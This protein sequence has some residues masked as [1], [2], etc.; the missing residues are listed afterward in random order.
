MRGTKRYVAVLLAG[1]VVLGSFGVATAATSRVKAK[2]EK[3]KPLHT[4][5]VRNDTVRWT[6]PTSRVHDLKA[7][8]GEWSFKTILDPGESAEAEVQAAGD[9]QVPL[10]QALRHRRR[11]VPGHVRP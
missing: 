3:W 9:V 6:N 11:Q 7:Y 8:G 2:G 5:I 4:Y 10:R 1:S